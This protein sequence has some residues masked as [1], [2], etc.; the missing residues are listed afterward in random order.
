MCQIIQ[1]QLKNIGIKVEIVS[2]EWGAFIG[3]I[4]QTEG[5]DA[6]LLEIA[7]VALDPD[8]Y[9]YRLFHSKG[10]WN[11]RKFNDS[12]VDQLLEK[13]RLVSDPGKRK[14]IYR[15]LQSR[16]ADIGAAIW[17]LRININW[18]TQPWVKGTV[19]NPMVAKFESTW[20]DK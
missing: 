16:M 2:M 11:A 8:M 10:I 6:F 4:F 3:T 7:P 1:D 17:L 9:L 18:A 14:Q 20:L 5:Y 15:D 19:F 12:V 13:G